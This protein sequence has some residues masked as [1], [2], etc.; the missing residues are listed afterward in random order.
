M[1][2]GAL[3]SAHLS[4]R[5]VFNFLP[6]EGRPAAIDDRYC[7]PERK[8]YRS[9][10]AS[11]PLAKIKAVSIQAVMRLPARSPRIAELCRENWRD[12]SSPWTETLTELADSADLG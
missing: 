2:A 7:K 11:P 10:S 1:L 5:S 3:T 4:Y 6:A 12:Q 8:R 9:K